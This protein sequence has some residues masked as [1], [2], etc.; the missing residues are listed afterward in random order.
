MKIQTILLLTEYKLIYVI[1]VSSLFFFFQF[2]SLD[3]A[4]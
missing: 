4:K 3:A 2:S 1:N